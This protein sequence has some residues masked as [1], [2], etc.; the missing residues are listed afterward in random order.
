VEIVRLLTMQL[1]THSV[2]VT[3]EIEVRRHMETDE[4]EELVSKIDARLAETVPEVSDTFWEL[5]RASPATPAAA[6]ETPGSAQTAE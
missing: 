4:I 2:L 5:R 3:G 6:L 1:G